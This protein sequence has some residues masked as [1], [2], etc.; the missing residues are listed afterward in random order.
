M[1]AVPTPTPSDETWCES[2]H[3]GGA[4]QEATDNNTKKTASLFLLVL[5]FLLERRRKM[6]TLTRSL[7]SLSSFF[8]LSFFFLP[9][10]SFSGT[11]IQ[12]WNFFLSNECGARGLPLRRAAALVERDGVLPASCLGP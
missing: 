4:R 9:S 10:L 3:A 11:S 7:P 8:F 1:P 6:E 5:S 12:S 2:L